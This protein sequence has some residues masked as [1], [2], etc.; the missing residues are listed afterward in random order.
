[1]LVRDQLVSYPAVAQRRLQNEGTNF[2]VDRLEVLVAGPASCVGYGTD[3]PSV[4]ADLLTNTEHILVNC[5]AERAELLA[6]IAE[7]Y[8]YLREVEQRLAAVTRLRETLPRPD[9]NRELV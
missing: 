3:G 1:M 9:T 7:N 8:R 4:V 6:R 5:R 2:E